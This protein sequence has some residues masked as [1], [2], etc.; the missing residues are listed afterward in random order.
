M[1]PDSCRIRTAGE[2]DLDAILDLYTHLHDQDAGADRQDQEKAFHE[3]R[4]R[5][6]NHL[7]VLE[8][9][10][11]IISSCILHILPNLTRGARPYGLVENVVTRREYRGLGYATRL[12]TAALQRAWTEDCYKV[13]L[14]TGRTDPAVFRLY[15]KAGF[16]RGKKEALITFPENEPPQ[17]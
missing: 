16:L 3:I 15:E 13:M 14:M 12:L 8:A 6:G 10:G 1:T 17:P 7:F 5:P 9:E 11:R 4:S 2:G